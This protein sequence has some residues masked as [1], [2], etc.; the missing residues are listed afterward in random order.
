MKRGTSIFALFC[1][2][3]LAIKSFG[4]DEPRIASLVEQLDAADASVRRR[5]A[6]TL[7][8]MGEL[9]KAAVSGINRDAAA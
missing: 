5:A 8:G 9:A 3:G 2:L 1:L 4:A 7:G 6:I